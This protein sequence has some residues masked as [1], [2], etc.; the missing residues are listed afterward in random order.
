MNIDWNTIWDSVS[1]S[2]VVQVAFLYVVI[3]TILKYA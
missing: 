1:V 2:A 3:Y